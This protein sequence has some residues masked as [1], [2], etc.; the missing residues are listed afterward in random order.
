M[1]RIVEQYDTVSI[2]KDASVQLEGQKIKVDGPLGTVNL[3]FSHTAVRI[4]HDD[5][6]NSIALSAHFLRKKEYGIFGTVRSLIR[7]AMV[8]VTQGFMYK[9]KIVYSHF[10]ISVSVVQNEGNF[11]GK[12][13]KVEALY[14]GRAP[15]YCPIVEGVEVKVEG[16]DVIFTGPDKEKVGQTAARLQEICR[17]RGKRRKSTNRPKEGIWMDGLWVYSKE[18]IQE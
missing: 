10:P 9:S 1:V 17:L 15:K 18:V 6:D 16:E 4:E 5:Q 8:G 3:D 2:A 12:V 7:N 14:G 13:I 11:E